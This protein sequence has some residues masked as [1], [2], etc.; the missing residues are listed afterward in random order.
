MAFVT[1]VYYIRMPPRA[2]SALRLWD[3]ENAVFKEAQEAFYSG[4]R[5][6]DALRLLVQDS[7]LLTLPNVYPT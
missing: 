7:A 6:Q 1:T 4:R 5:V 2:T 3:P